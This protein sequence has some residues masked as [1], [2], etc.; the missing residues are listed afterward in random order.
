MKLFSRFFGTDDEKAFLDRRLFLLGAT[1][2][3]A[4]LIIPRKTISIPK[5][6]QDFKW[7]LPTTHYY[8]FDTDTGGEACDSNAGFMAPAGAIFRPFTDLQKLPHHSGDRIVFVA[9]RGKS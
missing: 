8:V 7:V 9:S 3:A 1:M 2:T 6:S 5:P 4:G